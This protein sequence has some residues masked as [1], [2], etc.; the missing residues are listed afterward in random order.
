M[1]DDMR[2]MI[3]LKATIDAWAINAKREKEAAH[4]AGADTVMASPYTHWEGQETMAKRVQDLL[5]KAG[6]V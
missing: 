5:I 3:L 1:T 4:L 2:M 6:V